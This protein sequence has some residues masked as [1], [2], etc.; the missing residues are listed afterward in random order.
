M[1]SPEK[2]RMCSLATWLRLT[3]RVA[4]LSA[5]SEAAIR[6]RAGMKRRL[7]VNIGDKCEKQYY[8]NK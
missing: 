8:E 5:E 1:A 6:S 7:G 2:R 3:D 4:S